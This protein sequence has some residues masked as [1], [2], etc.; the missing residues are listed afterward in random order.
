MDI[1]NELSKLVFISKS[2]THYDVAK[3]IYYYFKNEYICADLNKNTWY[4][5][6]NDEWKKCENAY[7]LYVRI[8]SELSP[9]Y[10][11]K[12]IYFYD[13]KEKCSDFE[14]EERYNNY[15]SKFMILSDKLKMS[16]YK[17]A[18]LKECKNLFFKENLSEFGIKTT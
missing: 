5:L 13:K 1:D 9:I 14:E 2:M 17:T 11:K 7:S 3:V 12:A 18:I 4:H 10:V 15:A 6:K 8:S 16:G